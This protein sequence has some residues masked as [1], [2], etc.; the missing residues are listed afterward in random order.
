M[1]AIGEMGAR[2]NQQREGAASTIRRGVFT[3]RRSS[4]EDSLRT[5]KDGVANLENLT[6]RNIELEPERRVRCQGRLFKIFR[7]ASTSLYRALRSSLLDWGCKHNIGLALERRSVD[8]SPLDC[9]EKISNSL[10]YQLTVSYNNSTPIY[11]HLILLGNPPSPPTAQSP[12]TFKRNPTLLSL[13]ILLT[14]LSLGQVFDSLRTPHEVENYGAGTPLSDCVTAERV[15]SQ[16][17]LQSANY[18]TAVARCINGNLHRQT[19]GLESEG[20][21]HQVLFR[22]CGIA[23]EASREFVTSLVFCCFSWSVYTPYRV[24]GTTCHEM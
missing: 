15:M 17:R 11:T 7:D 24:V 9:D 13:G 10:G 19:V 20:V 14:E 2:I 22:G 18:A 21:S 5:I 8:I 23:R 16:V 3:A 6:D 4:Y 12:S 1:V